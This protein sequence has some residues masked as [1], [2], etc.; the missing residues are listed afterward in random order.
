MISGP[1]KH[2][3]IYGGALTEEVMN[4]SRSVLQSARGGSPTKGLQQYFTPPEAA[5]LIRGVFGHVKAV[6]DPTAGAGDLLAPYPERARFGIEIDPDHAG[7]AFETSYAAIQADAQNVVPMLRAAGARWPAVVLNP[8]FGL[9]WRD[10]AHSK[11]GQ[12][13]STLLAFLWAHDLMDR[14]GQGAMISGT[15]RLGSAVLGR[16]EARGIYAIVDVTGPFFDGV[17]LPTSIAFFVRPENLGKDAPD[18][19]QRLAARRQDLDDAGTVRELRYARERAARFVTDYPPRRTPDRSPLDDL[20]DAFE[21]V[22][23]EDRKRRQAAE[24]ESASRNHDLDLKGKKV[25]V[26]LSPYAKL[27]LAGGGAEKRA[28]ELLNG[29]NVQYFG[30]NGRAWRQVKEARDQGLLTVSGTLEERAEKAIEEAEKIS[31]PLFP[32]KA[33]MRLGWLS[34][35]DRIPCTKG[36]PERGYVAGESYPIATNQKV[37]TATE[38]R[39]V[40]NKNGEHELRRFTTERKLLRVT[41]G[42]HSF[43]EG[44][45]SIAY[46]AEHFE[47]PDP[48]CVKSRHPE[49][50]ARN[51]AVLEEIAAENGFEFKEF[52]IDHLSRLLVKGR[53]VL[54]HEQGLG[55]TLQQMAIAEA[56]PRIF[57]RAKR[58][59]LFVSPQDLIDQTKREARKFFGRELEEIRTPAQ[60]RDVARR[61]RA[62]EEGWW[63]THYELLSLVGRKKTLLPVAP[64]P[65]RLALLGRLHEHKERKKERA[66]RTNSNA[67]AP[68]ATIAPGVRRSDPP[69]RPPMAPTSLH[70]CP[71]CKASGRDGWDGESCPK[72]SYAHRSRYQ[73]AG[74]AHLTTAF[75]DGVVCVDELSEIR[76]DDSLRSKA[77]RALARGPHRFGGTGTPISNY[78]NDAYWGLWFALGDAS[79]AFPYDYANGKARFEADFCVIEYMHGREKDGEEHLRKRRKVLPRITNVSQ[80]WRLVQPSVSRCRKEQ[81]GEPLVEKTYYPIRVPLGKAQQAMNAFWLDRF[82]DFFKW[83]NP[84]HQLVA[85]GLV[86]KW[87]AALGQLW[88]L[89]TASTLPASDGPTR[90]WPEAREALGEPSNWTPATLKVLELAKHHAE[91][92]EKVLIGSDLIMTGRWIAD[93]LNEKAVRATH[94]TEEKAGKVA[95]KN[96]RKRAAEVASFV[97]GDTQVLTAGV[98]ALKLGHNLDVASVVILHGLP[99]SLMAAEQFLAR[100]HRL[101]SKKPVSVYIVIPRNSIAERKWNLLKDKGDAADLA[102]DGELSVQN[103][104]IVDWNK[105]LREMREQGIRA[106]GDEVLEADVEAAWAAVPALVPPTPKLPPPPRRQAPSKRTHRPSQD[107]AGYVQ[108]SLF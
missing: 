82:P 87:A 55:K 20:G 84:D 89:E 51:R 21:A 49:E 54:A 63:I 75:K 47:L 66:H 37:E 67:A 36:C 94:I 10:P 96:P 33:Q 29:Q 25:R 107:S 7:G 3:K 30:Q 102:F 68:A 83:R 41:V 106:N 43:D 93:R 69:E 58:Q 74:Y 39:V 56:V 12:V 103:E 40:E 52:Q 98:Q 2:G 90:E 35:L 104:E 100:V 34:D 31:T 13:N 97:V 70:A 38:Q 85:Q 76:G 46:L 32:L 48:G 4:S 73:K 60:A 11:K 15:D 45:E 44:E 92:G 22:A 81:T 6:L 26:R 79:P 105:V 88:R 8:P 72:C 18:R 1:E 65:G 24:D 99:Y 71:S 62:G 61:V 50:V 16:P 53:G 14:Y 23:A 78:V 95:T 64:L 86:E 77:I 108:A 17:S 19:P 28:L 27:A 80:F 9:G 57:P 91:K 42:A 5:R 101:T 59:A